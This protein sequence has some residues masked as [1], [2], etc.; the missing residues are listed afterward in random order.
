[1]YFKYVNMMKQSQINYSLKPNS[2]LKY[3]NQ[4]QNNESDE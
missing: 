3:K 2:Y 1:M 4:N